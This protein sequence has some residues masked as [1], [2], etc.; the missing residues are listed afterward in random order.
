MCRLPQ[1]MWLLI[2]ESRGDSN[3]CTPCRGNLIHMTCTFFMPVHVHTCTLPPGGLRMWQP[4]ANHQQRLMDQLPPTK[5][6]QSRSTTRWL[7]D[8]RI[9]THL[10]QIIVIEAVEKSQASVGNRLHQFTRSTSPILTS[11]GQPIGP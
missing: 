3:R 8:P 9:H 4:F 11:G 7:T 2:F 6:L 1:D 10:S 5:G